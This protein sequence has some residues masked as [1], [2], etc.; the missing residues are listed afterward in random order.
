M[1]ASRI[2]GRDDEAATRA[3]SAALDGLTNLA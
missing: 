2:R 1:E 3:D